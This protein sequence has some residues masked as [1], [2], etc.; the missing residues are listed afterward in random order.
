MN[1]LSLIMFITILATMS[2]MIEF[3][4]KPEVADYYLSDPKKMEIA[5]ALAF[6]KD[7]ENRQLPSNMSFEDAKIAA[8]LE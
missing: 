2:A 3:E 4:N 7:G 5:L 6:D 1:Y 8:G